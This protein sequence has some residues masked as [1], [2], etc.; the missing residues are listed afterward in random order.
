MNN[1]FFDNTLADNAEL[2]WRSISFPQVQHY[3]EHSERLMVVFSA[4]TQ[5]CLKAQGE[6][7]IGFF[8]PGKDFYLPWIKDFKKIVLVHEGDFEEIL[9]MID[10]LHKI[11]ENKDFFR[12]KLFLLIPRGRQPICERY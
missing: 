7:T 11:G 3:N 1:V 10:L 4:S 9:T 8:L 2:I 6:N 5:G 12:S